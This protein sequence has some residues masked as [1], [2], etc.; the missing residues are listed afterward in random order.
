MRRRLLATTIGVAALAVVLLAVPL[1]VVVGTLLTD[2]AYDR[3]LAQSQQIATFVDERAR[4]CGEAQLSLTV[5]A[6]DDLDLA[7]VD[8]AGGLLFAAG[9]SRPDAPF[10]DLAAAARGVPGRSRNADRLAVAVPLASGVC[11]TGIVLRAATPADGLD[12]G[13]RTTRLAIAALG[14]GVLGLAGVLAA[15]VGRRLARPFEE[16]A[17][18]AGRLGDGDFSARAER[19]GVPEA[20]RIAAALDSTA[21]R[22]GRAVAR[23]S[24]FTADAS[25]QLRT[26]LTAL[27]LHL[28]TLADAP[29]REAAGAALDAA[30]AEADRL[31]ATVEELVSLTRL[32]GPVEDVD[33]GALVRR[34]AD[35]WRARAAAA[36]RRLDVEV[37]PVPS[38]RVRPAAVAQALDVLVDNALRHGAGTVEVRVAPGL[39]DT[40]RPAVRVCVR[41]H[42]SG[43]D[44]DAVLG[45]AGADRGVTDAP[46]TG[47]RGLPLARSLVEGEGGR[48]TADDPGVGVRVC[49]VLPVGTGPPDDAAAGAAT[50]A[51]PTVPAR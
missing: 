31:E 1:A 28:D 47:G 42:G 5:A 32:D 7:L 6:Q 35:A 27:R 16:L 19:S 15:V 44:L 29:D 46:V 38:V 11:G 20:D 50:E 9:R 17:V 2:R 26:P 22:L 10:D 41:D 51:T 30:L 48:L 39:P 37:L 24:A 36:D 40:D 45:A 25:H 14:L 8:R 13:V 34:R 3:L 43:F 21:E 4:T 12:A 23:G 18:T 33:L 49:L